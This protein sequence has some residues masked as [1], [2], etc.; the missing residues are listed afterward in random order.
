[1]AA[2][3]I[4]FESL[5]VL[6]PLSEPEKGAPSSFQYPYPPEFLTQNPLVASAQHHA[7]YI[8]MQRSEGPW[9]CKA[10]EC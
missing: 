4:N 8:V 9:Q 10:N 1:M 5:S 6:Q 3:V 2:H 7:W